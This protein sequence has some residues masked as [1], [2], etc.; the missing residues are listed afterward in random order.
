[1]SYLSNFQI[2]ENELKFDIHNLN[3]SLV[4]AIRRIIISDVPTLGFR[5]ENGKESDIIIIG[6]PHDAYKKIITYSL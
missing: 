4:N 1:M 6:T 3:C 2:D 5:T